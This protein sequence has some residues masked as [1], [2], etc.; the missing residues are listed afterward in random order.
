MPKNFN[1]F[2][3]EDDGS[4]MGSDRKAESAFEWLNKIKI[5]Y[6]KGGSLMLPSHEISLGK[7]T[8]CYIAGV[9][10]DYVEVK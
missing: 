3:S 4:F 1:W 6:K 9:Q 2:D 8:N 10:Y 5:K 7:A